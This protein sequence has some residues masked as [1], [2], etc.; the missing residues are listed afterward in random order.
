[1][2]DTKP[3]SDSAVGAEVRNPLDSW[4][5]RE[6]RALY[7]DTDADSLPAGIAELAAQLEERLGNAEGRES[8][9]AGEPDADRDRRF[10]RRERKR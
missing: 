9:A 4:L 6:L 2:P 3:D 1:M 8:D 5:R 10:A 7:D